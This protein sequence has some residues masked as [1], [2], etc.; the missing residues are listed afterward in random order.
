MTKSS[1]WQTSNLCQC[2]ESGEGSSI[3]DVCNKKTSVFLPHSLVRFWPHVAYPIPLWTSA[4]SIRKVC[5]MVWQ[6]CNSWF[7]LI[8]HLTDHHHNIILCLNWKSYRPWYKQ[9]LTLVDL[10]YRK[11]VYPK[12]FYLWSPKWTNSCK[13]D[14]SCCI[15][16]LG[17]S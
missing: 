12:E 17:E 13:S 16:N 11:W 10:D 6:C 7:S 8:T 9:F 2:L 5:S 15:S 3:K 1:S 4:S 14:S